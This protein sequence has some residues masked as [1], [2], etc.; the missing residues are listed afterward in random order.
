MRKRL[1]FS[2]I[3]VVLIQAMLMRRI[4][5]FPDLVLL[6]VVFAGIFRGNLE[7]VCTG[8]VA[9]FLRGC[10]S[11][12]ML[13]LDIFLFPFIGIM[14]AMMP[15]MFYRQNPAAQM[16]T[17]LITMVTAITAHTLYLNFV[18]GNDITVS[19][20]LL[21]SWKCL[22]VTIMVSPLFFMFLKSLLRMEE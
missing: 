8:F 1:Y 21:R 10:F 4:F 12:N 2:L 22:A 7:G 19:S 3:I 13:G 5:W 14:S 17:V 6:T 16:F 15:R 20:V 11:V 9:G 18:G